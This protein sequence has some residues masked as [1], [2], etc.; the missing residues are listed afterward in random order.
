MRE[1]VAIVAGGAGGI[2]AAICRRFAAEGAR[3]VCADVSERRGRAVVD[4][5]VAE[6]K[7]CTFE[8]LDAGDAAAWK[9]L[10]QK[11]QANGGGVDVLATSFFSGLAGDAETMSDDVWAE[12]FRATSSGVFFAMRAVLPIMR[13]G[14]AIINIASFAAHRPHVDN[15]GYSSAK[16]AV[17]AMSKAAALKASARGVRVNV[18][19]PGMIQ[20]RA[21]DATMKALGDGR[22]APAFPPPPLGRIGAPDEI[23]DVVAFLASDAARYVTGAEL[24]VDGGLSLL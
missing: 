9:H 24:V 3:V 2:G 21:L 23:A 11:L 8:Q 7:H 15:I 5:L 17:I 10:A 6:G 12:C 18:V 20:T 16:A 13:S 14:G 4:T 19:T 22:G 1:R